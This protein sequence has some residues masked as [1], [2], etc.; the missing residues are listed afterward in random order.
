MHTIINESILIL[1]LLPEDT[2]SVHQTSKI[3]ILKNNIYT[4]I[5]LHY[6]TTKL[7]ETI[8]NIPSLLRGMVIHI[9]L[10]SSSKLCLFSDFSIKVLSTLLPQREILFESMIIMKVDFPKE[11]HQ[12]CRKNLSQ[13]TKSK[14]PNKISPVVLT[15]GFAAPFFFETTF[16]KVYA[17]SFLSL[18]WSFATSSLK[19]LFFK[20]YTSKH[21]QLLPEPARQL[22]KLGLI[23]VLIL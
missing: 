15:L 3:I 17:I 22:A 9:L 10:P 13:S 4:Y 20:S 6:S 23:L 8:I 1:I 5:I 18:S 21:F 2:I 16:R 19:S 7:Q 11:S 12:V 14:H